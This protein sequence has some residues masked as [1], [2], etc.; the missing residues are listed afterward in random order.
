MPGENIFLPFQ[1]KESLYSQSKMNLVQHN[2]C[3]NSE[4]NKNGA[5]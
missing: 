3:T 1:A 4:K 2:K 5:L